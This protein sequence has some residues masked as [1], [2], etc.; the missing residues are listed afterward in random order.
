M[1]SRHQKEAIKD[2]KKKF[3]KIIKLGIFLLLKIIAENKTRLKVCI[4]LKIGQGLGETKW[5]VI[6]FFEEKSFLSIF[7]IKISYIRSF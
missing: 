3:V 4:D 7:F 1:M 5:K 2:I 6:T